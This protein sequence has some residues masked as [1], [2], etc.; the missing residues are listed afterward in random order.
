MCTYS[1]ILSVL[2]ILVYVSVSSIV[3]TLFEEE[4]ELDVESEGL[5][6]CFVGKSRL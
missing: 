6:F 2:T 1:S 5:D 3:S 4:L